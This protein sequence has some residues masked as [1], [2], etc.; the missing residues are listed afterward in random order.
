MHRQVY[1][2]AQ[3]VAIVVVVVWAAQVGPALPVFDSPAMSG[4][5]GARSHLLA[6]AVT[7]T[8]GEAVVLLGECLLH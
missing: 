6:W 8:L 3:T 2:S 7:Q 1:A 4:C 5:C